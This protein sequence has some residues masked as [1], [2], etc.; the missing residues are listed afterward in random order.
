MMT[1]QYPKVF[2]SLSKASA[3]SLY[4]KV[5]PLNPSLQAHINRL[6]NS[7]A[8]KQ[9]LIALTSR[10]H[11]NRIGQHLLP[12]HR[13][14]RLSQRPLSAKQAL[15]GCKAQQTLRLTQQLHLWQLEWA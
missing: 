6:M 7:Q 1:F 15:Q 10:L 8:F 11:N 14:T 3:V 12:R 4:L 13:C 2:Y 5:H 9:A